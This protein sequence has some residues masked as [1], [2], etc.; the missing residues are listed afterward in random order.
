MA[1]SALVIHSQASN[2][3]AQTKAQ[4]CEA[5]KEET[6]RMRKGKTKWQH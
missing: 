2:Q 1:E 3:E 4:G 5:D 6:V